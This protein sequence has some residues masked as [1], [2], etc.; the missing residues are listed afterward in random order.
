MDNRYK[1]IVSVI[2]VALF[3]ASVMVYGVS[4]ATGRTGTES[5]T[6]PASTMSSGQLVQM[7]GA[8]INGQL[9]KFG[10]FQLVS[11]NSQFN[12]NAQLV[13]TLSLKPTGNLSSYVSAISNPDSAMYRQY[14][15]AAELG[16]MFGVSQQAYSSIASYFSQY[17]L[18][19][20]TS[21]ARL[22]LTLVGTVSQFE[23]AFDTQI[24]AYAI[25][26]TSDGVWMPLFGNGS[27]VPGSVSLSPVE[28]VNT[29][30]LNMPAGIAQYVSG[31]TG[32]D[33]MAASPDLMLPYGMSPS[34]VVLG[35]YNSTGSTVTL[36]SSQAP[37]S[38]N[39]PYDLGSVQNITDANYTW[40]P[41][42]LTPTA[43]AF[44]D[45]FGNYQFIFPSTLA[46]V[47]LTC[48][49]GLSGP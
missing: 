29:A 7:Q 4:N 38:I 9:S 30:G 6:A 14:T 22:S 10:N 26:Y 32:L 3:V 11:E 41:N 39:N 20:Q 37:G 40:A 31:V 15:S 23:S 13:V 49:G 35:L 1:V 48:N 5:S 18:N 27:A 16:T 21:P 42:Y 19:V 43:A 45:P 25:Q 17:G 36:N 24:G 33:G 12:P 8:S 2:V 46:H 47:W 44:N 34:G 28:Y